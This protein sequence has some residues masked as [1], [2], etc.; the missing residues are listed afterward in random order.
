MPEEGRSYEGPS[1]DTI[2]SLCQPLSILSS[3]KNPKIN[4]SRPII[5]APFGATQANPR[6]QLSR[7]PALDRCIGV[8]PCLP[9]WDYR[10]GERECRGKEGFL[11]LIFFILLIRANNLPVAGGEKA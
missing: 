3:P 2:A 7:V 10:T 8:S 11:K 1:P 4:S 9:G 5:D 6:S